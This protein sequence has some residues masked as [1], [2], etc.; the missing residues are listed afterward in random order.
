MIDFDVNNKKQIIDSLERFFQPSV[1]QI[2]I[3]CFRCDYDKVKEIVESDD[4]RNANKRNVSLF[5]HVVDYM[6]N[7]GIIR[8][9]EEAVE[10]MCDW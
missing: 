10:N 1:K 2:L 5:I 3:P 6:P 8:L 9:D 4:V 7:T